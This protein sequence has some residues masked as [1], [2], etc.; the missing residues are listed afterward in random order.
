MV[1]SRYEILNSYKSLT[2]KTLD[3]MRNGLESI[4]ILHFLDERLEEEKLHE[5]LEEKKPQKADAKKRKRVKAKKE[6]A[7]EAKEARND[8]KAFPPRTKGTRIISRPY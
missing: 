7:K 5:R 4:R 8:E 3:T 1:F 6:E 2:G